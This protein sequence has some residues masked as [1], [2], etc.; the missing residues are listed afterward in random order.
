[1]QNIENQTIVGL[2]ASALK[3]N[4][5]ELIGKYNLGFRK[6]CNKFGVEVFVQ[7]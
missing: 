5:P 2:N 4:T 7:F 1:M 3:V 6:K